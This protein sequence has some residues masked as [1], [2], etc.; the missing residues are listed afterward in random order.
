MGKEGIIEVKRNITPVLG[1]KSSTS[2]IR[3]LRLRGV[4]GSNEAE[5]IPQ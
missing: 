5:R 2:I 3:L 1:M 4:A